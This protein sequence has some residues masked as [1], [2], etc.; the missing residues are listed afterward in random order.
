MRDH[1]MTFTGESIIGLAVAA[2]G[3]TGSARGIGAKTQ[4]RRVLQPQPDDRT[5]EVSVSAGKWMG[6]GPSSNKKGTA[7]WDAWRPLRISVGDRIWVR[8]EHWRLGRWRKVDG[9]RVFF[10]AYK[11]DRGLSFLEP[12][13]AYRTTDKDSTFEAY[14]QRPATKLPRALS[15]FTLTVTGVRVER[16]QLISREDVIAEGITE[17]LG[18]PIADVHTGWYEP[19]ANLWDRLNEARGWGWEANPWVTSLT[20]TVS[21]TNIDTGKA[22]DG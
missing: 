11:S 1:P 22:I 18:E 5:T 15:R 3:G 13:A 19:Y 4:T 16:L 20:F 6:T 14:W 10:P 21:A 9:R 8:E 12:A 2:A 7:Q 17:R